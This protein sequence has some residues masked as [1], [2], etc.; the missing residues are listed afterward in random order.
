[1]SSAFM[2][3]VS[4]VG[5]ALV[6]SLPVGRGAL[7]AALAVPGD[8]GAA[9]RPA[10]LASPARQD[11]V[12]RGA[13]IWAPA[14]YAPV[15]TPFTSPPELQNRE[16][17]RGALVTEYP[18]TFK[19][20]G[21]GG[22]TIVWLYVDEC[23]KVAGARVK[24][25]SGFEALD[26]AALRV[27]GK[28]RWSPARNRDLVVRV[29]VAVPIIFHTGNTPAPPPAGPLANPPNDI[30]Y[31]PGG[32]RC[33]AFARPV[34]ECESALA[35]MIAPPGYRPIPLQNRAEIDHLLRSLY[36]EALRAAGIGGTTVVR[37]RIEPDGRVSTAAVARGS[38]NEAIDDAGLAVARAMRF[39]PPADT[40]GR[41]RSATVQV[42]IR[43][44]RQ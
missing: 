21:Q 44:G 15:Y 20:A 8:A 32:Q 37:L 34:A 9:G 42:P 12:C 26:E 14:V 5:L 3:V 10:A 31:A 13:A 11:T 25:S 16:E 40:L 24:N 18:R 27:A 33:D 35:K 41:L 6:L 22:T 38:G 29:W 19:D 28:M 39:Y 4:D 1:M 7:P 43:F 2:D 30:S 23:G 17:V 36:P